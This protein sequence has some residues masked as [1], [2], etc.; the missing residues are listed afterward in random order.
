MIEVENLSKI[1]QDRRRGRITAVD[2]ISFTC[3]PGEIFGLLGPN[4]AGKTTTLRIL[5]TVLRPTAGKARLAGYD[6]VASPEKVREKIG[7]ISNSTG[8]Y[9][10]LTPLEMVQYFGRLHGMEESAIQKR[11]DYI[12]SVLGMESFA[13]T[14]NA[15]LSSGMRQKVSI[16]R[17]LV[18]DPP[19]LIFDEPTVTLDVLIAKTVV[20]FIAECRKQQK[21]IILSTHVMSEA[22]KLCDRIAI[23]HQGKILVSG[24]LPELKQKT[25]TQD[26]ETAFFTF[27][28]PE[29]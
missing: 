14:L 11:T 28:H 24:T 19:V 17:T 15:K 9:E 5:S 20:D 25:G 29:G 3:R 12:F 27:V 6:V 7:F 13:N 21:C 26:L 2:D 4:G 18:H 8:I 16:A 23:I 22:E 1:F 10:R